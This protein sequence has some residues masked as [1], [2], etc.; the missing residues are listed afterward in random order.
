MFEKKTTVY[1]GVKT[2]PSKFLTESNCYNFGLFWLQSAH[3]AS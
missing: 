1:V 2:Q 3:T